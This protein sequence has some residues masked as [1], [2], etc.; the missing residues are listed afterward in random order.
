ML[1]GCAQGNRDIV[2]HLVLVDPRVRLRDEP[3][4][5]VDMVVDDGGP[6]ADCERGRQRGVGAE[7]KNRLDLGATFDPHQI[8]VIEFAVSPQDDA[9][10]LLRL[11]GHQI[12]GVGDQ[13]ITGLNRLDVVVVGG[14]FRTHGL[15]LSQEL[16]Q[17]QAGIVDIM[18]VTGRNQIDLCGF[19]LRHCRPL[20]H[21]LVDEA[22]L[23][24]GFA[25]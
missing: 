3:A 7:V 23:R 14:N 12:A 18:K 20:I 13:K 25:W 6:A 8:A 4:L 24:T 10:I 2:R 16:E 11:A 9:S 21:P 5:T 17:L 15:V 1:R 19:V 22:S